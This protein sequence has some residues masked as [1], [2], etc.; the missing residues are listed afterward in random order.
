MPMPTGT[1]GKLLGATSRYRQEY[2]AL[3][4]EAGEIQKDQAETAWK[5]GAG[6]EREYLIQEL[7]WYQDRIALLREELSALLTALQMENVLGN[8]AREVHYFGDSRK[9][10]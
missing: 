4:I 6:E 7:S 2:L 10:G 9:E 8:W 1:S 3:K 5:N